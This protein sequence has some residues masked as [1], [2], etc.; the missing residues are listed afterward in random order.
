MSNVYTM[1]GDRITPI[2]DDK[3]DF[4]AFDGKETPRD[5]IVPGVL[6]R[7]SSTI[8]AGDGGL[9]KS[10]L[11]LQLQ[12][13][14]AL[15]QPWIG[16]DTTNRSVRS[17]GLYCEDDPEEI[18]RRLRA[19]CNYYGCTYSHLKD[20]MTILSRVGGNNTL[21]RFDRK[22]S[23][24]AVTD[25]YRQIEQIVEAEQIEVLIIDTAADTFSGLEIDREQ[26]RTFVQ[27]LRALMEPTR[28]NVIIT[29]HPSVEGM[30]SG[31][32]L[33][34][35]TAWNNSVRSRMYLTSVKKYDEEGDEMPTNERSLKFMK[36]NYGPKGE[37]LRIVW[38]EGVFKPASEAPGSVMSDEELR[39]RMI[40]AACTL[41]RRGF[42]LS[43]DPQAKTHLAHQLRAHDAMWKALPSGRLIDMCQSLVDAGQFEVV[44]VRTADRK[45]RLCIRPNWLR[46]EQENGVGS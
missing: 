10:L 3:F 40:D 22:T 43:K 21:M 45:T 23:I 5:W 28:G 25:L 14:L 41:I 29:Q 16:V 19:I 33:S 13:A 17:L 7:N 46:Y 8:F 11:M 32:G 37:K 31:T 15:G 9:G 30:K 18:N 24:G 27:R 26:V 4:D 39:E 2:G 36:S 20:S 38:D 12:V 6:T 35:S 1:G 42:T 34:G 44:S